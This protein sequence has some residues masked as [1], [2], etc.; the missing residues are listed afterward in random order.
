MMTTSERPSARWT[1][2]ERRPM[3]SPT[4]VTKYRSMPRPVSCWARYCEFVS[5]ISPSSSS[6]PTAMISAFTENAPGSPRLE[7]WGGMG[8]G[9]NPPTACR[10]S[11]SCERIRLMDAVRTVV[12][13]LAPTPDQRDEIEATLVAFAQACDFAADVAR[14]IGST[15]KV[16]VQQAGYAEIRV[17]FGLSAN[18]AIRAIAR[19]CAALKVPAKMRS[20]FAPT[21]VDYD[22]RIF[23]FRR[24]GLDLRSDPAPFP[25][26]HQDPPW[27]SPAGHA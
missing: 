1:V 25:T 17:G 26:A 11:V 27:G 9:R 2:S 16:K 13:K 24:V 6:V 7:A 4:C 19:A 23:R 18:L 21:S 14:E 12:C 22:A 15:N 5:R 3:L 8:R 10:V 20:A